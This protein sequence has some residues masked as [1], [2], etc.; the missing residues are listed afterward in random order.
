VVI[1][2]LFREEDEYKARL[3]AA[4]DAQQAATLKRKVY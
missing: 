3:K 2:I 4:E 1:S